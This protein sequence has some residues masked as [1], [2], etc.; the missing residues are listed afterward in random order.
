MY[1]MDGLCYPRKAKIVVFLKYQGYHKSIM[2]QA[3]FLE[4][5]SSNNSIFTYMK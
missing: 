5:S 1:N 2:S 3:I 4:N